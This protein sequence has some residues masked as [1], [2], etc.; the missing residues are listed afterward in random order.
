MNNYWT[1]QVKANK[2]KQ[3]IQMFKKAANKEM[4]IILEV[5][6]DTSAMWRNFM[7]NSW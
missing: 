1:E 5:R 6:T 3:T 7:N 4:H 2:F